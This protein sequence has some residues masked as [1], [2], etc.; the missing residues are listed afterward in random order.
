M[1]RPGAVERHAGHDAA[2]HQVNNDRAQAALDNVCA[3]TDDDRPF[4]L[5][6]RH[7]RLDDLAKF[8]PCQDVRQRR[9]KVGKG[10]A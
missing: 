10:K 6:R 5:P 8:L 3:H 9:E 7:H 4:V 1:Y 2:L